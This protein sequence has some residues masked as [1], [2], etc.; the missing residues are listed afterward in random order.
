VKKTPKGPTSS[1]RIHR[2]LGVTFEVKKVILS[3]PRMTEKTTPKMSKSH[4]LSS[5]GV[6]NSSFSADKDPTPLIRVTTPDRLD[7]MNEDNK[8]AEFKCLEDEVEEV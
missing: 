8:D 7:T 2:D 5:V 6:K 1:N 3:S 4:S